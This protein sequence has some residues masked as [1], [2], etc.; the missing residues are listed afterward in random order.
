VLES[1][2][3]SQDVKGLD[4]SQIRALCD[5]LRSRLVAGVNET[6]GHLSSNLG[7]VEL[8]VALHRVFDST[9]DRIVWDV[10]HQSYC[11]KLLTGRADAFD[12]LRQRGG[13][14]GFPDPDESA[15]DAFVAGHAGNSLSAA[16]GLA[17]AR[18]RACGKHHVVAVVGDGCLTCGM[19]YEALNHIGHA[20]TRLIVVLNDNGMSISPTVGALARRTHNLRAGKPYRAVKHRTDSALSSI[21]RGGSMRWLLRRMKAG[22]KAAV[23]PIMLFEELGI[24][25]LGPVEGHDVFEV[26]RALQRARAL[27]G[28]VVVHVL[29]TKGKGY[30]PAEA[31]PIAFHGLSPRED[32]CSPAETYSDVFA[33]TARRLLEDDARVTVVTAA[34]LDGTG[35]AGLKQEYPK[36]VLDV[37]ISE[38]HAVT[39]AAGMAAGGL[40]P[41]VAIYS[42]FLQR[43]F[44]QLVHDVCLPR[45]PVVFAVDRAGIVGEDGKTHQGLFDIGYLGLMPSM[46]VLAPR[47]AATLRKMLMASLDFDSPVAVRYPRSTAE[48]CVA[49]LAEGSDV[50]AP[51]LLRE[52]D[53]ITVV[54]VGSMVAPSLKAARLASD[55]GV[56][57]GVIDASVA[58]PAN[59]NAI[60]A[61][62]FETTRYLTVEEHVRSKGFGESFTSACCRAGC[63]DALVHVL[64]L[65]DEF[66][67]HGRRSLLL[68]HYGLDAPGIARTCIEIVE[69]EQCDTVASRDGSRDSGTGMSIES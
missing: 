32:A 6:G 3:G 13:L 33:A 59:W 17:L 56:S 47:D 46:T 51:Q 36:R 26:E 12:T 8:T 67:P 65:P 58:A 63:N 20:R 69:G 40:R 64:A 62:S 60:R 15:H 66:V 53:D 38:Q 14:S 27:G 22:A 42:T 5:E 41:I 19:T 9:T 18:D 34:M 24:T 48:E 11:H 2:K 23:T 43:A 44:D 25:Y 61:L 39:L 57:V 1:I 50:T 16:Q 54:A 29:T 7:G 52:G 55:R 30:A 49:L 45:L 35:L 37:G 31:D 4:E 68:S 10:G 28:P 21:P